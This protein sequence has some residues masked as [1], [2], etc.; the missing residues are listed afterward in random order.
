[1]VR[2]NR[3]LL[4]SML[5]MIVVVT[6]GLY[7]SQNLENFYELTSGEKVPAIIYGSSP[8]EENKRKKDRRLK[9]EKIAQV[10]ARLQARDNK[11]LER[12]AL[13]EQEDKI[14]LI[15]KRYYK[16]SYHEKDFCSWYYW[17][18]R[19]DDGYGDFD[20]EWEDG[21][22]VYFYNGMTLEEK[23]KQADEQSFKEVIMEM[24]F[25]QEL[26][27]NIYERLYKGTHEKKF[28]SY[29]CLGQAYCDGYGDFDE[30]WEECEDGAVVYFYNRM[31]LEE[32]EKHDE[33]RLCIWKSLA[34]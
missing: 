5:V 16:R 27:Q 32:K 3:E 30:E 28:C 24:S 1:M 12:D 19:P 29:Y 2:S 6:S 15:D 11:R 20:E 9:R 33:E 10:R 17:P 22:V 13:I 4:A 23:E 21:V 31:T 18:C 14:P 7:S 34:E 26:N 25:S 8:S